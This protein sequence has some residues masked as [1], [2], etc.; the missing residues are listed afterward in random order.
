M[1]S[2]TSPSLDASVDMPASIDLGGI[3]Y[4]IRQIA[5]GGCASAFI[6]QARGG[7][8]RRLL[9]KVPHAHVLANDHG[10]RNWQRECELLSALRHPAIPQPV[11][12]SSEPRPFMAYPYL[13]G[14]SLRKTM[15]RPQVARGPD[16]TIALG[17]SLLRILSH[18]HRHSR[19]IAH[20]DVRPENVLLDR[21]GH[22]RLLD[23]GCACH[24]DGQCYSSWVAA[25]RYLSPEQAQGLPW[26]ARSDV[27]QVGLILY[28]LLVAKPYNPAPDARGAILEAA[29]PRPYDGRPVR[30][31]AGRAFCHWLGDVLNPDTRDRM[32]S[33]ACAANMLMKLLGADAG[34]RC[35]STEHV[36]VS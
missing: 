34:R 10:L 4:H 35:R 13:P 31:I 28:E 30:K 27:Y 6:G 8:R 23:F 25:P 15:G 12:I 16:Q 32:P 19:P 18:L 5:R 1:N 33:A 17:I 3:T 21:H 29:R 36:A 26:D 14:H 7:A 20:G 2:I 9:F 24:V 11:A 22:V